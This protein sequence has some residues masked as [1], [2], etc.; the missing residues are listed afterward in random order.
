MLCLGLYSQWG[1]GGPAPGPRRLGA[2]PLGQARIAATRRLGNGGFTPRCTHCGGAHPP[3]PLS[4][5]RRS[6]RPWPGRSGL[7][8]L[9]VPRR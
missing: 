7:W 1:A 9:S 3:G 8:H 5:H 4:P 6:A 2:A